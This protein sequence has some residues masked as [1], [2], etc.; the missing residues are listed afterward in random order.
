MEGIRYGIKGFFDKSI[1]YQCEAC[2]TRGVVQFYCLD[3]DGTEYYFV[4][5]SGVPYQSRAKAII[6]SIKRTLRTSYSI[7]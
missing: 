7:L 1:E 6:H 3:I 5:G 4:D 2:L